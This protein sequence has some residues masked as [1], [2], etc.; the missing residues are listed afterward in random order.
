MLWLFLYINLN[1]HFLESIHFF[2]SWI[3]GKVF[4]NILLRNS[5]SHKVE[6][7]AISI[8]FSET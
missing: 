7:L 6:C 5:Q 3:P 1:S 4:F 2:V 8:A